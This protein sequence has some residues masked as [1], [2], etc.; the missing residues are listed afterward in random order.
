MIASL[1]RELAG[2]FGSY[3]C[4]SLR[5]F[6]LSALK[7]YFNAEAAEIRRGSPRRRL[8]LLRSFCCTSQIRLH[9]VYTELLSEQRNMGFIEHGEMI[10]A[11]HYDF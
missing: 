4:G 6:A 8:S 7:G 1:E 2:D 3:L 10:A 11:H 5:I 9:E